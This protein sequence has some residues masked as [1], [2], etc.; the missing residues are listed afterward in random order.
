MYAFTARLIAVGA[1]LQFLTGALTP[2]SSEAVEVVL[3]VTDTDGHDIPARVHVRDGSGAVFPGYPDST[4]YGHEHWQWMGGYF[5]Y[6]YEPV[7]MNLAPGVARIEVSKGPEWMPVRMYPD[8]QADTSL[9]IPMERTLCMNSRGWFSGDTHV[10]ASHEPVEYPVPPDGV[11]RIADAEDLNM[12][13]ILDQSDNFTGGPHPL[14]TGEI[15]L[16][17]SYEYRNQSC[18]HVE[19]LG[20]KVPMPWACCQPPNPVSPFLSRFR[21]DWNPAWDEAMVLA[22]P[23]TG[24]HFFHEDGWPGRG[25]GREFPVLA[26]TGSLDAYAVASY[27]NLGSLAL[28]PWQ[29]ALSCGFAIPPTAGTDA[30]L[31]RYWSRPPGGYRAYVQL[32]D[33][34]LSAGSW[35]EGLKAGRVFITN[36]PLIPL[37]E[38]NGK[39]AGE[40]VELEGQPASVTVEYRVES[41]LPVTSLE[42]IHNGDAVGRIP[43]WGGPGHHVWEGSLE[44]HV[45]AS[46]WIAGRVTGVTD[47]RVSVSPDL[48]AHTGAVEVRVDGL[49][50]VSSTAA[51]YLYDKADSLE[52]F[53]EMRGNWQSEAQRQDALG[54]I[55]AT[56]NLLARHFLL[57]PG[58]FSLISPT[59]GDTVCCEQ[60][61]FLLWEPSIDPENGDRVVYWVA[62]SPD[63]DFSQPY[64][65]FLA[66]DSE[67]QLSV[68][69]LT[70]DRHYWWRVEA[71]DRGS[72]CTPSIQS[73]YSFF[74]SSFVSGVEG[75]PADPGRSIADPSASE[76]SE[77]EFPAGDPALGDDAVRMILAIRP[78][79]SSGTVVATLYD[80]RVVF[81]D[82]G[83]VH[84]AGIFDLQGR[85]LRTMECTS[86]ELFWDGTDDLGRV[87]PSGVYWIRL[88][89]GVHCGARASGGGY[90]TGPG[91]QKEAVTARIQIVR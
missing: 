80:P 39:G 58:P 56:R 21:E 61:P 75:L 69:D 71:C 60:N 83:H 16:Y 34:E 10:H 77:E 70:P 86:R 40:L 6:Q 2:Q 44:L 9:V 73:H 28:I 13:W 64:H 51:G 38:V 8:L 11:F 54:R 78:N 82:H 36:F 68:L 85:C 33:G 18:G 88:T 66:E 91:G 17:Y 72:N 4:L 31:C 63:P 14:S 55:Q 62:L 65:L 84:R 48:F 45:E 49:L 59:D 79:P 41:V 74:L 35:V 32:P 50:P 24:V 3:R 42:I 1:A 76:G 19:L 47:R 46:G 53:V 43:L 87:V 26:A 5:Y 30:M 29:H 25:L 20:A 22:H 89:T 15:I 81:P 27:S 52:M 57:Y 90:E 23:E 67:A 7:V 37:F 12:I